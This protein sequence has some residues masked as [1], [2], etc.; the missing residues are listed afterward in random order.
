MFTTPAFTTPAFTTAAH[1]CDL[2]DQAGRDR[3]PFLFGLTYELDEG[4]F[5]AD[6]LAQQDVLFDLDGQGNAAGA[7][8]DA[9][10]VQFRTHPES[11]ERYRQRFEVVQQA[12]RRGDS[13]LANLTIATPVST[14]LGLQQ[15]FAGSTALFRLLVPGRFVCF[16][17]ERFVRLAAGRIHSH[18]MKGTIDATAPRAAERLRDDPKE[19]AEHVTT[20]DLIRNDLA[21][22][23]SNVRVARF[24][25]LDRLE[26][27]SGPILQA[28][29]ELVGDLPGDY[30]D[31]LGATIAALLPAGSIS[32]APKPATLAMLRRAEG[33]PRGYY[34]GVAG[35]FDGAVLDTF[36]LI[37]YLEQTATGLV[38]RSGGGI[39]LDSDPDAEYAEALTKVYLPVSRSLFQ[40]PETGSNGPPEA[41][42]RLNETPPGQGRVG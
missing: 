4:F 33:H 10:P 27:T 5:V 34:T 26:T 8:S 13:Y 1:V 41:D 40:R 12:L 17:P 36:V 38:F 3:Q 28:S 22:V 9:T 37:R 16:T 19:V 18:P 29:S 39:T 21:L 6:P 2:M 7:V 25:Y 15:I 32:G 42:R 30:L 20:V 24:R 23:A 14:N 11:R 35:Y 31:H